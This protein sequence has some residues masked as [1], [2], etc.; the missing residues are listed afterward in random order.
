MS[1]DQTAN[2][3]PAQCP[4]CGE[5]NQCAMAADPDAAECWCESEKFPHDLLARVPD[6]A[7]RRAC[8]CQRCLAE[9]H[10]ENSK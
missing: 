5:P 6:N 3:Y 7:A 9:H 1:E 2:C 10:K 8:I 4:L